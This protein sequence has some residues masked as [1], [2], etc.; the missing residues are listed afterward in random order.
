MR[1]ILTSPHIAQASVDPD[2]GAAARPRTSQSALRR[3]ASSSPQ[4][5]PPS[6]ARGRV[7]AAAS[8]QGDLHHCSP[9]ASRPP[10]RASRSRS[11][12]AAPTPWPRRSPRGAPVDV[13][14]AAST[15]TMSTV[16]DAG[17]RSGSR[18]VFAKNELEIA[19]P[20]SNPAKIATLA[21]TTRSGVK[22]VLCAAAV[23]CGAAAIKAY[24]AA[25][26]TPQPGQ[27]RAGRQVGADQ[28][29]AQGGRRRHRLPDRRAR[30]PAPRSQRRHR[31]PRPRRPSRPTRSSAIKTGKNA[32]RRQAPSSPTCC[33][34][35]ATAALQAAGF[36]ARVTG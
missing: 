23:P 14:A 27:P 32:D 22:L 29:R 30:R 33:P 24:A 21:D 6:P 1:L 16:T 25:K 20:P 35:P 8:L 28:G 17:T 12:S 18:S 19:V 5:A 3:R 9:P 7:S 15:K 13:F 26:L 11:T 4:Q 10:T 34:R 36:L 31:S 2:R